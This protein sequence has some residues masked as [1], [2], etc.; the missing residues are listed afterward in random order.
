VADRSLTYFL[1]F[2]IIYFGYALYEQDQ[3]AE[4]LFKIAKD[5]QETIIEQ[6]E[7]IQAQKFY[8]KLLESRAAEDYYNERSPIY[9]KPL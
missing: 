6:N 4:R 3:E 9:N 1:F 5:Q 7:A 8:I 2:L